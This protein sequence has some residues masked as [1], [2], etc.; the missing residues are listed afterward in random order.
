MSKIIKL[1][2][3]SIKTYADCPKKYY[4]T[5]FGNLPK[6]QWDHLTLGNLCHKALEFFHKFCMESEWRR[7]DLPRIM[8][9]SFVKAKAVEKVKNKEIIETAK[10]YLAT[11]MKK[12]GREGMPNVAGVE[13]GW[14]LK[15]G[16]FIMRGYIDRVDL[17]ENGTYHIVD[18][19]TGNKKYLTDFQLVVYCMAIQEKEKKHEKFKASY[20]AL[21]D[22]AENISYIINNSDIDK[23]KQKIIKYGNAIKEDE[24]WVPKPSRLCDWCDFKEICPAQQDW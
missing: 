2:A 13:K 18:Y 24:E 14:D 7:E 12:I 17:L 20:I 16:E 21:K 4:Y 1:S 19:K 11:Y 5:Y 15:V 3:S 22:N 9:D 8:K 10:K 23:A 6:K